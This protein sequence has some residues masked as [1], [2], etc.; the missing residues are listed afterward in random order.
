MNRLKKIDFLIIYNV[1]IIIYTYIIVDN[2]HFH[3][4]IFKIMHHVY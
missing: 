2:N 4:V 3:V 1:N